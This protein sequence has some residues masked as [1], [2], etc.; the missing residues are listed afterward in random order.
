MKVL[1]RLECQW[2]ASCWRLGT[3]ILAKGVA[4]V[5]SRIVQLWSGRCC[6][7]DWAKSGGE[8]GGG[9]ES[10][11][12][13]RRAVARHRGVIVRSKKGGPVEKTSSIMLDRLVLCIFSSVGSPF[14]LWSPARNLCSTVHYG[15]RTPWC[16]FLKKRKMQFQILKNIGQEL[17][18]SSS[19]RKLQRR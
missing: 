5:I 3:Y 4:P 6:R 14:M 12:Y 16:P 13:G 1:Y 11:W 18:S 17:Y 9:A 19:N 7:G 8:E 2:T 10:R 15:A